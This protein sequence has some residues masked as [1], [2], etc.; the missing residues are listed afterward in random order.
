MTFRDRLRWDASRFFQTLTYF[1]VIPFWRNLRQLFAEPIQNPNL[2]NPPMKTV[3]LAISHNFGQQIIRYF[4]EQGYQ[5]RVP[6]TDARKARMALGNDVDV[7]E[8]YG[9]QGEDLRTELMQGVTAVV[10][11]GELPGIAEDNA[12]FCGSVDLTAVIN[13]FNL[14]LSP[15]QEKVLFDFSQPALEIEEIW[16]AVDD[17]V[18]GGVS[19]SSLRLVENKAI[20]SGVVSTENNGGFAS[21]RTRNFEPPLDLSDYPGIQLRIKGDG[22]RYKF[23][24]RDESRWDGIAYSYSF[25]AIANEWLTVQIPFGEFIPVFRAKSLSDANPLNTRQIQAMQLMHSKFEYDRQ[26]NPTFE[27]GAFSLEIGSISAYN[28]HGKPQLILVAAEAATAEEIVKTSGLVYTIFNVAESVEGGQPLDEKIGK[29]CL[30]AL[31]TP[32]AA[33]KTVVV[34]AT[35]NRD[36]IFTA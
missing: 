33:N 5:V 29:L 1:D 19:A 36:D 27:P 12:D 20:F 32:Q 16:G 28:S 8:I 7:R 9:D 22:K 24:L 25:D 26:L 2:K 11:C 10:F 4:S 35:T 15:L 30:Q 6:V 13:A 31:E 18:M 23:I 14:E 34:T 17:V 3:F 21:V